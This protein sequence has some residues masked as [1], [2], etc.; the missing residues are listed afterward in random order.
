[1]ESGFSCLTI[2]TTSTE[3]CACA[4]TVETLPSNHRPS[5]PPPFVPTKMHRLS[6]DQPIARC[7]L[8]ITLITLDETS[9]GFLQ[10][11]SCP[12][13]SGVPLSSVIVA[14]MGWGSV[15]EIGNTSESFGSHALRP[16]GGLRSGNRPTM[17]SHR[18]TTSGCRARRVPSTAPRYNLMNAAR[19]KRR[20]GAAMR[21]F[22]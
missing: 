1:M 2:R 8:R 13:T 5:R 15:D 6:S 7:L 4:T 14:A 20:R 10:L 21:A 3:Q 9:S 12:H 17:G 16:S 11:H 19:K 22:Q 18:S